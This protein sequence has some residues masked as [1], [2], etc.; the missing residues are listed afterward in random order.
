MKYKVVFTGLLS[1]SAL[2]SG[3]QASQSIKDLA[4]Q[5]TAPDAYAQYAKTQYPIVLAHGLFG[6][7]SIVGVDYFYQIAPDLARN[8]ANIWE[9]R[10]STMNSSEIR[11]EQMLSQVEEILAITGKG[12]VNLIGHSHGGQSVRYVAGVIPNKVS[13]VTTIGSGN[14]GAKV[15]DTLEGVL[16]GGILELP[17]RA[18]FDIL[19][20]PVITFASGL[21]PNV[22]PYDAKAALQAL[23]TEKSLEFNQKFPNGVPTSSCGEGAYQVNGT[24][25]YSFMGNSAFNTALDPSDYGMM[26]SSVFAGEGDGVAGRCSSR[27]GK[28]IR[29]NHQWNHLDEVNQLLGL[30]G[31]FSASPV[32]VYREH[33]NRLKLQGL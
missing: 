15:A 27:F 14:K 12:K 28:V 8:G 24:Y 20:S 25:Y 32:Q 16:V 18:L 4:V 3:T 5:N 30:R 31:V 33:A 13:S 19:V 26:S 6:F 11:G 9:T 7:G 29:D 17:A 10:V 22:F 21:D 1:L 23:G 2:C